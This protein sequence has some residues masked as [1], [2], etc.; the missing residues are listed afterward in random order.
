MWTLQIFLSTAIDNHTSFCRFRFRAIPARRKEPSS[1]LGA[2]YPYVVECKS[3]Y[4]F[5][6]TIAA[7]NVDSVAEAY[8]RDC[9]ETNPQFVYR[10]VKR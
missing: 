9:R 5:F 7:F 8:A 2:N 4:P 1:W 3:T 10:V 6:E